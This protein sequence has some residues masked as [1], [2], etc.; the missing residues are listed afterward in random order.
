MLDFLRSNRHSFST[1]GKNQKVK[2]EK[3]EVESRQPR[4]SGLEMIRNL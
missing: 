3:G 4:T 1:L 2:S